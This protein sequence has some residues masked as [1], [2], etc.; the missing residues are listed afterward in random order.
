M[1]IKFI[2]IKCAS[3]SNLFRENQILESGGI[4]FVLIMMSS[5]LSLEMIMLQKTAL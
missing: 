4:N 2:S 1:Y 5:R 3:L